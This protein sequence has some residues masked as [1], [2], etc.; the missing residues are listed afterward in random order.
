ML[1]EKALRTA[2]VLGVALGATSMAMGGVT[3][4]SAYREVKAVGAAGAIKQFDSSNLLDWSSTALFYKSGSTGYWNGASQYATF[5][6]DGASSFGKSFVAE[7]S[8]RSEAF[9]TF[10]PTSTWTATSTFVVNFTVAAGDPQSIDLVFTTIER[11]SG[12]VIAHLKNLGTS[13]N[14]WT[15]AS[16]SGNVDDHQ[17]LN[18]AAGN[19]QIRIEAQSSMDPT[20]L[21]GDTLY[22]MGVGFTAVPGPSALAAVAISAFLRRR[23]T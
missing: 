15:V 9:G 6:P 8:T 21:K 11:N 10:S 7:G 13:T 3:L 1:T 16:D 2:T 20:G 4:T 14:L 19:Y 5:E 23:R 17:V 18:L 12:Y 22:S